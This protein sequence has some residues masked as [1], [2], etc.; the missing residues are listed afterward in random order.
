MVACSFLPWMRL[1]ALSY[2]VLAMQPGCLAQ[3]SGGSSWWNPMTWG[4]GSDS[5]TGER[6]STYFNNGTTASAKEKSGWSLPTFPWA[7]SEKS[8]SQSM[9]QGPTMMSR[10]GQSTRKA[11]NST[12]DF[13]NPFNDG[14]ADKSSQGYQPAQQGYQPQNLSKTS[15]SGSGPFGW[16]WREEQIERPA[17]VNDFLKQERPRF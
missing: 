13:L 2:V 8:T 17:S 4:T 1:F 6:K 3:E 9:P 14:P 16:M 10:M 7:T 12:T 5:G 11:W 15:K